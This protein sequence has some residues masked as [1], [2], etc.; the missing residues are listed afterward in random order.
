MKPIKLT[1]AGK[2]KIYP[3]VYNQVRDVCDTSDY[4]D[5]V[6]NSSK[7]SIVYFEDWGTVLKDESPDW[8]E[9]ITQVRLI[10]W[11]NYQKTNHAEIFDTLFMAHVMHEIPF[12]IPSLTYIHNIRFNLFRIPEKSPNLFSRYTYK[13]EESQYLMYPYDYFGLDYHVIYR[14]NLDCL[15]AWQDDIYQCP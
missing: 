8:K 12:Q 2:L 10:C 14:V 4:L 5:A 6:P 11:F 15:P 7:K 1:V 3:V 9:F 13:E